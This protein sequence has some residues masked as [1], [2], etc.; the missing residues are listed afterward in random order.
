MLYGR[1][2]DAWNCAGR[3]HGYRSGELT[4]MP[5]LSSRVKEATTDF[6]SDWAQWRSDVR[7]NPGLLFQSLPVRVAFWLLGACVLYFVISWVIVGA[8]RQGA[9]VVEQATPTATLYVACTNPD[10][11]KAATV[12]QPRNFKEWP[13]KCEHCGQMSM[14]RATLCKSCR[15]WFATSPGGPVECLLC[16]RN[17]KKAAA[18]QPTRKVPENRDDRED[19]WEP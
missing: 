18:S 9:V 5:D 6:R 19:G 8:N 2:A 4:F 3:T 15:E 12:T 17:T 14:H 13:L 16:K 10:C 1:T 11:L 7:R